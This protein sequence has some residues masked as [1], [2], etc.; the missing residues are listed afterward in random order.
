MSLLEHNGVGY[1]EK[2]CLCLE[3]NGV[4]YLE[5]QCLCLEHNGMEYLEKKHVFVYNIT[6]WNI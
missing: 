4:G 5:K 6:V 3:H 1:L 2:Q